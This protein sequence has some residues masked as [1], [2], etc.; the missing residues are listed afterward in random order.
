MT[1]KYKELI[2]SSFR[3]LVKRMVT[4][5]SG[6]MHQALLSIYRESDHI[7]PRLLNCA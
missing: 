2:V 4:D 3:E 1:S 6:G 5:E 7:L